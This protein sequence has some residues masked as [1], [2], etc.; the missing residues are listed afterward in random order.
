VQTQGNSNQPGNSFLKKKNTYEVGGNP[1]F[2][3]NNP[4]RNSANM[5]E[6]D[7]DVKRAIL[8]E[9]G[10]ATRG[11]HI[12]V[13]IIKSNDTNGVLFAF[14]ILKRAEQK[15]VA[16]RD[17]IA[18]NSEYKELMMCLNS[19]LKEISSELTKYNINENP[20]NWKALVKATGEF[21]RNYRAFYAMVSFLNGEVP[22]DDLSHVEM[23]LEVRSKLY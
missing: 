1:T 10:E 19:E 13:D 21:H 23:Q 17:E 5:G 20:Q 18:N 11:L 9:H 12:A 16:I 15:L 22:R 2:A 6:G 8:K 7:M 14:L 4:R 3:A